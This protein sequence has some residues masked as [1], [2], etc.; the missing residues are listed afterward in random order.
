MSC[1]FTT[2]VRGITAPLPWRP[3][4]PVVRAEAPLGGLTALPVQLRDA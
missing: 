4:A 3:D 1:P 2:G